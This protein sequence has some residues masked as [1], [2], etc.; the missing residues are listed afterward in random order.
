M[1]SMTDRHQF[2]TALANLA[3]ESLI[4]EVSLTPKPGLVDQSDQGAHDD[5]TYSI[6]VKSAN[7]LRQTFYQMAMVAFNEKPSQL[8]RE[9]IG[10]IGRLGEAEMFRT[11]NGVNTHKGAI[12]S[13]GLIT[14]AAAIHIGEIDEVKLCFTAGEI[15]K[16]EDR[17]IP[18]KLTNGIRVVQKY[19][20]NGAKAEAQL[21]FPHVRKYSLPMLKKT[22]EKFDYEIAKLYSFLALMANLDDTC[23]LHRGGMD[24]L[25]YAKQCAVNVLKTEDLL[26]LH[27]I[28]KSFIERNLSPGGSADLL[29]TTIY[30][31]KLGQYQFKNE[32]KCLEVSI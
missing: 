9:K 5:L 26:Q 11:T 23:L 27:T 30:L 22:I 25:T 10:E 15:A 31:Y 1:R 17:F 19:G 2:S 29:A 8:L 7:C 12:W 21:A 3:V 14:A 16:Y 4:E 24:G 28:N 20:V 6:M 18:Q 13:L 32:E